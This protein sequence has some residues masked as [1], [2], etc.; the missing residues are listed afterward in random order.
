MALQLQPSRLK[1]GHFLHKNLAFGDYKTQRFRRTPG[2]FFAARPL[3]PINSVMRVGGIPLYN[4]KLRWSK[5]VFRFELLRAGAVISTVE[6]RATLLTDETFSIFRLYQDSSFFGE[7]NVDLLEARIQL[8][9]Q[10]NAFWEV[11][12]T[13]LNGTKREAQKG[14]IRKDSITIEFTRTPALLRD[15]AVDPG[16][17]KTLLSNLYQVYAFSYGQEVVAA[18]TVDERGRHKKVWFAASLAPTLADV[19]ASTATILTARRTIYK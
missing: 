16:N 14:L 1:G 11:V 19:I 17:N 15:R 9:N 4:H 8:A 2:S 13:N 5:D 10:P 7:R 12:A 18:V 6:C 3:Q